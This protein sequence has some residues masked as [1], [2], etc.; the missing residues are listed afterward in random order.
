MC[1]KASVSLVSIRTAVTSPFNRLSE[2]WSVFSSRLGFR[3]DS[4]PINSVDNLK[5]FVSTRAAYIAQRTLYGYVK[6]RMGTRYP[7]MFKD[8]LIIRSVNI[9]KMHYFAAC[10]S[11]LTIYAVANATV[12]LGADDAARRAF[13]EDVYKSAL[14]ENLAESVE[15]FS[16]D[17]AVR[18]FQVR[19]SGTDWSGLALTR[20]NFTQSP[21]KLIE[22]APIADHL[23]KM[24][25]EIAENSVKFAWADVRRSFEKRLDAE[26][27]MRDLAA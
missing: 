3:P 10:L 27:V 16:P 26:A 24:D 13:A 8:D 9:A 19:L 12:A 4:A 14:N 11:D 6:T 25:R 15:E 23:K 17:D 5:K 7:D 21:S 22:W 1:E 18:D 2:F 20:D